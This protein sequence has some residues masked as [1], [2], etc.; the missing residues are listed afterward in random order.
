MRMREF[1]EKRKLKKFLH[2]RYAIGFLVL[3]ALL[4]SQAVLGVHKK[5]EKS[6]DMALRAK[7]DLAALAVQENELRDALKDLETPEGREREVRDRFGLVKENER[8]I[9]LVDNT[10]AA[11]EVVPAHRGLWERF[12]DL[13]R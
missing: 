5:Y 9:I 6:K 8:L 7:S 10:T 1:Q 13:W 2:S 12:L 4:M 11:E 3:I